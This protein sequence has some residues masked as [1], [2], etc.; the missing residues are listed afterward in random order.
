M[1]LPS[2]EIDRLI[3]VAAREFRVASRS[4][5]V[6]PSASRRNVLEAHRAVS[7]RSMWIE[8]E[9]RATSAR[10]SGDPVFAAARPWTYLL[11]V[12]RVLW[13]ASVRVAD[14][15]HAPS[16]EMEKPEPMTLSPSLLLR[17][18]L[19]DQEA[20]R[21][22]LFADALVSGAHGLA[23]AF[24]VA[25][26]RRAEALRRL[27]NVDADSIEIPLEPFSSLGRLA[28]A[29][30]EETREL[31]PRGF[32][33][34]DDAIYAALATEASEG[35][36]ARLGPRWI[37]DLFGKTGLL[38]GLSLAPIELPAPLGASSFARAL[39]GFGA[40]YAEADVPRAAPFVLSHPPFD[41]RRARRAALFGSLPADPVFG[42]R[43]LGLGRERA[44]VQAKQVG[45]S[46][47]L[48]L[49]L[50]A[51]RVLLR[52][53]ALLSGKERRSRFEEA[54]YR[55]LGAPIPG[56]LLFVLPRLSSD[57]VARFLGSLLAMTDRRKLVLG[58]DEDWFRNPHAMESIRGEQAFLPSSFRVKE[59]EALEAVRDLVGVLRELYR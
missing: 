44:R 1:D 10:T 38:D 7:T 8:L 28:E 47:L 51:A 6:E 31:L 17:R 48:S 58:F 35:W 50:D 37:H 54:T 15:L 57:D 55:A 23:D 46:L 3:A 40:A 13:P 18:L 2:F 59:A 16:I 11:T 30:L 52:G 36:P 9:E 19:E 27:G 26:E 49:R 5:R 43:A 42:Q 25:E 29:V 41:L 45:L 56:A 32:E 20:G 34:F 53:V 33:R 24:F 4:L 22:R 12:E 39:A 14:A 21:R